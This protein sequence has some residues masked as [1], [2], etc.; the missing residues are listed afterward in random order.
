MLPRPRRALLLESDVLHKV[1]PPSSGGGSLGGGGGRLR[2]SLVLKLAL[3]PKKKRERD[4]PS[5]NV[6]VLSREWWGPPA[7]FGSAK[8]LS[9]LVR[10]VGEEKRK[11]RGRGEGGGEGEGKEEEEEGNG[12][13]RAKT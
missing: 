13:R 1:C 12:K 8:A 4:S 9:E 3:C 2:F 5:G 10:R 6:N 7:D 11:K